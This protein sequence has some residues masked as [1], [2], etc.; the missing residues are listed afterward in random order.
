MLRTLI[1]TF[2]IAGLGGAP[3]WAADGKTAKVQ[4]GSKQPPEELKEPIR[5]LLS[6]ETVQVLDKGGLVA[7]IWFRKEIP[8]QADPKDIQQ[9][10]RYR[11]V[12]QSTVMGAVR[13]D[14][15]WSDFRGQ[16]VKA[17]VYTLRLAM[18]PM[19]GD[20]MGT[21]PFNEFCLLVP[22]ALDEK[23][24]TMEFKH[25]FELSCKAAGSS[26]A[27]AMLLYPND[28]PGAAPELLNKGGGNYVLSW[29]EPITAGGQKATLGLGMTL[30]GKTTAE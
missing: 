27:A 13:F 2:L 19:D 6:D 14:Q 1:G 7:E 8:S 20:H 15:P 22:A 25:L 17:G 30:F 23:P 10:A 12:P 11:H 18:Q 21:A 4:A 3:L 26:H 28:K 5:Q 24:D 16:K 29:K 9:V